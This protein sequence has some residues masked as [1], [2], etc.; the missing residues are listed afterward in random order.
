MDESE[1]GLPPDLSP[2][3]AGI[4]DT[5]E[6]PPPRVPGEMADEA[7]PM[8]G[9]KPD[10]SFGRVT[11]AE[12]AEGETMDERLDREEPDILHPPADHPGRLVE[13]ESEL[14]QLDKTADEV[15]SQAAEPGMGLTAEE[16]A[17]RVESESKRSE[18]SP[19]G[20]SSTL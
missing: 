19:N 15:A 4:P 8:P 16:A 7:M 5:V 10:A 11:A 3:V 6:G 20:R 12:E 18:R 2:D 13:P 14:D 9:D 17:V 1:T